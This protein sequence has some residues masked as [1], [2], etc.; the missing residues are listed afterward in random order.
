MLTRV[1]QSYL[2]ATAV[3]LALVVALLVGLVWGRSQAD[4]GGGA[5]QQRSSED[6]DSNGVPDR[7]D[8]SI[9]TLTEDEPALRPATTRYAAA[10]QRVLTLGS[11]PSS[12]DVSSLRSALQ[13]ELGCGGTDESILRA[14]VLALS[15]DTIERERAYA[16]FDER[17]GGSLDEPC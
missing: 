2:V 6:R 10:V 11:D 16:R 12:E 9:A 5:P 14:R 15:L 7:L 17:M 8:R 3:F 1:K 13:G 4:G